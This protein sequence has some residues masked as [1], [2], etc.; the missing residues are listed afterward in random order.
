M[1]Q[2]IVIA[3]FTATLAGVA[4]AIAAETPAVAEEAKTEKP[5]ADAEDPD[6]VI[7]RRE[8]VA[9]SNRPTKVC[10]TAAE[11]QKQRDE[12]RQAMRGSG[13]SRP[14]GGLGAAAP[15]Q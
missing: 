13:G 6:R 3:A 8:R 2:F 12:A 11:W 5:K 14:S 9:G 7:C 15:T 4:S 1:R 10:M